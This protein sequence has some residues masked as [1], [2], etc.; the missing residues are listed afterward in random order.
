MVK[1]PANGIQ[2]GKKENKYV[3]EPNE[4]DFRRGYFF[5]QNDSVNVYFLLST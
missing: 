1:S 4:K 3:T 2:N 5:S